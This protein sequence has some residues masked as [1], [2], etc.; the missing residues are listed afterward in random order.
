[1]GGSQ[2]TQLRAK[3]RDSGL[4]RQANPKDARKRAKQRKDLSSNSAQHRNAKLA[5]IHDQ[6]NVFD[7]RDEKKKFQVVSRSGKEEGGGTK[8]MPGRARAA[9]IEARKKTLLPMLE[10]RT[11]AST[12]VDHR[13]GEAASHLTPE[14]KALERFT[15][16]RKS[17]LDKKMRFNLED[18]DGGE[19]ALTHGGRKLGFGD[20]DQL[21]DGG[22]GGLG[23]G[24]NREPLMNRRKMGAE[25]EEDEEPRKKSHAEIMDEVIAK[26][27]FHKAERQKMK[28]ADDETRLELDAEL[29]DLRGILAG[30]AVS[31]GAAS[32]KGS[33]SWAT[34]APEP[35]EDDEEEDEDEED[36]EDEEEDV[37]DGDDSDADSDESGS[38]YE[39]N[40]EELEAALAASSAK[41]GVDRDLL[42]KL[43]GSAADRS[44]SPSPPPASRSA[45][46]AV[47]GERPPPAKSAADDDD[48]DSKDPYD[49]YVR[50]LAL[51]P[52]AHATNRLKTPLELAQEAAEQLKKQEERRLKRQR[53]EEDRWSDEEDGAEDGKRKK[54]EKKRAPQGDD[55][56]DFLEEQY[57]SDVDESAAPAV[58][59]GGLG[60]GLEGEGVLLAD[61]DGSAEGSDEEEGEEDGS[62]GEED[63]E[64]SEMDEMDVGD[65]DATDSEEEEAAQG[66]TEALVAPSTAAFD[67]SGELPY[68]FPCPTTHA[69]F[70]KLLRS[71]GIKD[72]DTIT[73]VKRIRTLYHPGLAEGNKEKL[74][75]F[76]NVL[77]DHIVYLCTSPSPSTFATVNSLLPQLLTM[78]HAYPLSSA[79]HCVSKLSLMHRNLLHGLIRGPLD[80]AAKTWPGLAELTL[81]RL[82]GM[83]WST[84]DLSHPV[85]APAL[86][87][88]GEYLS[89]A[90]VRSLSDLASGIFLVSLVAQFEEQSKRI[91]PEAVNFLANSLALLFPTTSAVSA[92]SF[93]GFFPAPDVGQEHAKQLK[94]GRDSSSLEPSKSINLLEALAAKGK[95]G[96]GKASAAEAAQLKVDL[97]ASA[98]KLVETY[99]AMYSESEAFI[100]VF[101]PIEA[102]LKAVKLEK[103][104]PSLQNNV[105]STLDA[106]SRSLTFAG[107][108]RRPLFLQHHKPIP[109]ATYLP[110]FDE[111]FNP[112]RRFDP[113]SERAAASKLRALYKK[114]K[115]GAVR[116]LR[117]DNKFLAV[118]SAKRRAEEDQQ[119]QRKV[120]LAALLPLPSP[121]TDTTSPV[122][123]IQK[124]VGSLQDERAEE[125]A[126]ERTKAK[127][128]RRDK[129]RA[130]GR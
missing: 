58:A 103:L 8:G 76:A 61:E 118:E 67:K 25:P 20:E 51:E 74:Q 42:R 68:T 15:A 26:S 63:E 120:C 107:Q 91:V 104:S 102:I 34:G 57:G 122:A 95:N 84:S 125:K 3:L 124:L 79:P 89:Q 13:F 73:V 6:F 39:L 35:A 115:K 101:R 31:R 37:E 93:P 1:M 69:E 10:A 2:L 38:T 21:E 53:G 129:A 46:A 123:Q 24:A 55:L 22:W 36:D 77:L 29:K 96:K 54:K 16:E 19:F 40:D 44:P 9:G 47:D 78:S 128:K 32:E 4:N 126:F 130:G 52:R 41:S 33:G 116:E 11:H 65:L 70:A 85:A 105:K 114:E 127:G 94:L 99:R 5:A 7:T 56:D 108:S 75:V 109:L 60:Q 62:E 88:I 30:G 121:V 18:D 49:I 27:K 117:N 45:S 92:T 113:D 111:G 14:E 43:I 80:P 23:E 106:L 119:Y 28:S 83:V 82:I 90:R 110:K 59:V 98:L 100:E 66:E 12:F 81:L 112:N 97:A 86:L 71:S 17:R 50:E 87:L 64:Q 48:E 72:E